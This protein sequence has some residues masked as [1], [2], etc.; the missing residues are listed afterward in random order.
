MAHWLLDRLGEFKERP[1]LIW[2]ERE[3]SYAELLALVDRW[4]EEL[5]A[6]DV[7]P[8]ESVAMIGDY[9]PNTCALMIALIEHGGIS[10]PL[11][12]AGKDN[13]EFL[14]IAEVSAVIEFAGDDGWQL[15][16]REVKQAAHPLLAGLRERKEPGLVV[17]ST[18]ST[19]KSKAIL[20]SF[21]RVLGKFERR[22]RSLR[23]L[24]FL[25]LD[26]FG[27]IN[28]LLSILTSGGAAISISERT[29]EAIC[30]AIQRHRVEVLPTSPTFLN[31]LL[32]SGVYRKFELSSLSLITYG[33]EPMPATTLQRLHEAFPSLTLKQTYGLTE[34]GVLPTHSRDSASLWVKAGGEGFETKVV[35]HV[36]WIRSRSAMLGYLNH[37]S[38]FDAEGWFNTHDVVEQD[39]EYIRIIGR[40]S[41]I[42]N[43]GG[44]KVYP[45]EV[46]S[47]LMQM[48]NIRDVTVR[49][50]SNPVT[51]TVV[52]ASVS[53]LSPEEPVAL[54]RRMQEFCK[55]R[56]FPRHKI[57]MFVEVVD[58][59]QYGARFKKM[60]GPA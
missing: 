9:S 34:T 46:E 55:A 8:G 51:G 15:Q 31:M 42:I 43:V 57:P 49:G 47:V 14:D 25:L 60:R 20:H 11:T 41:E 18:G 39:G 48:D 19:G 35:N 1:A 24:V 28:T 21:E 53:L 10:V 26:H 29:A 45:A 32:M 36:L 27:G 58:E 7:R 56:G 3:L 54:K 38:P 16:R 12:P 59:Q 37:P 2:R 13:T 5:R 17:F 50:K 30:G 52:A 40:T 4:R 33:T 23:T 22:R 6:R 44:E